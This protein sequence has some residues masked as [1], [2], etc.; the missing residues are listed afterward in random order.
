[1]LMVA[2]H[3]NKSPLKQNNSVFSSMFQATSNSLFSINVRD[4]VVSK[5]VQKFYNSNNPKELH[6]RRKPSTDTT[7]SSQGY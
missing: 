2:T 3:Q 1:M 6:D 4:F 7:Q 5:K